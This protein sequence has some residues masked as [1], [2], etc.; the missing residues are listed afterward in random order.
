MIPFSAQLT[1]DNSDVF[2]TDANAVMPTWFKP[3][4]LRMQI[5]FSDSDALHSLKVGN[6]QLSESSGPHVTGTDNVQAPDW[7]KPHYLV[8]IPQGLDTLD[9]VLD[10]NAVTGGVGLAVGQWEA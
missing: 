4:F 5:V 9:I 1:T 6:V 2:G 7:Q 10:H 8:A 3:R